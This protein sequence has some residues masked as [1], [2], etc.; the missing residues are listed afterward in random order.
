MKVLVNDKISPKGIE[1]LEEAGYDLTQKHHDTDELMDVLS[2]YDGIILR[3]A[4]TI[5]EDL[6]DASA[7]NL[8]VIAR[9]GTGLDNIDV[10]YAES[11][12]IDVLNTPG[13][14]SASVSELVFAHLFALARYLPQANLTMREGEWNKSDYRGIELAGKTLGIVGLGKI[15]QITAEMALNFDMDVLGYDVADI[16][17]DLDVD[18]VEKEELL[19]NSDFVSLHI[20]ASDE[21]FIG[22]EELDMMSEDAYLVNCARGGV[23]DEDALLDALNNDDIAG[24]G[25]D[26]WEEEPTNNDELVNNEKVSVTPHIGAATYEAQDRVGIQIA[27]KL[28]D[29]LEN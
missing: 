12:G 9:A 21:A 26:V 23:V 13:A 22:E 2:D 7:D 17:T 1:I 24:A 20:P 16:D 14:N 3:S 5:G 6:I 15:G 28:I 18:M 4:T 25:I 19:Q 27:E 10:D 11:K 8:K 29:A